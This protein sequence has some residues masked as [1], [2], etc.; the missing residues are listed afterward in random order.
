MALEI[1]QTLISLVG[2]I[3]GGG[4]TAY[5]LYRRHVSSVDVENQEVQLY[6]RA[7][8]LASGK[9]NGVRRPKRIILLRHGE[10]CGNVD[11]KAYATMPDNAMPLAPNGQEQARQ[12]GRR[13]REIIDNESAFF[14]VSPYRRTLETLKYIREGGQFLD[15]REYEVMEDMNLREQE[16]G[17]FQD[18]EQIELD[19][20]VRNAFGRFWYRFSNGESGADVY[21]RISLFLGTL[22]RWMDNTNKNKFDNYI[23]VTHGLTMRLFM[24]RYFRWSIQDFEQVWNPGNCGMWILEREANSGEYELKNSEEL[25]FGDGNGL[26]DRMLRL[27]PG[28]KLLGASPCHAA[29]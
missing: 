3:L 26:P 24:M 15:T 9:Y 4:V 23:I 29:L 22:Y 25:R 5:W 16:F 6:A 27:Y 28:K 20:Q 13:I 21:G 2:G 19:M 7:L 10:S 18:P 11:A 14:F 12:T 1:R 17:N 8:E